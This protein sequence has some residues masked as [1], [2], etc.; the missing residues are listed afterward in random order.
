MVLTFV[1]WVGIKCLVIRSMD[2]RTGKWSEM[3]EMITPDVKLVIG[4][5]VIMLSMMVLVYCVTLVKVLIV[6]KK[7]YEC[8]VLMKS[9]F[10]LSFFDILILKSPSIM[11][12]FMLL[13]KLN[14]SSSSFSLNKLK[15][16]SGGRY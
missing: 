9:F 15:S 13:F 5:L 14:K 16:E 11:H 7:E 4:M 8:R 12:L 6:G 1:F 10:T 2:T 3:S